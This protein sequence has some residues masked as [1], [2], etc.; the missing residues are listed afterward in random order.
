MDWE[1]FFAGWNPTTYHQWDSKK[2]FRK[3]GR[4][5]VRKIG[6]RY[7]REQGQDEL[8]GQDQN[9]LTQRWN[10]GGKDFT[11]YRKGSL[12]P[13]TVKT[14]DD[15]FRQRKN[16][17]NVDRYVTNDVPGQANSLFPNFDQLARKEFK[18]RWKNPNK[19]YKRAWKDKHADAWD[20]YK[21]EDE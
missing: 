4:D 5:Q 14:G 16:G 15:I 3:N 18:H 11:D 2:K 1:R 19:K 21:N 17:R 12:D 8:L 6:T 20:L 9:S 13:W 7:F 10:S